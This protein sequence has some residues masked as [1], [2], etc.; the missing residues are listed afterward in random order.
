MAF[1]RDLPFLNEY[2]YACPTGGWCGREDME[3]A[4]PPED[5]GYGTFTA[6]KE[7]PTR[8]WWRF[9]TV[10][11]IDKMYLSDFPQSKISYDGCIGCAHPLNGWE[12]RKLNEYFGHEQP[13]LSDLLDEIDDLLK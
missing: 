3:W 10:Q 2:V 9:A 8:N 1:D 13:K 11:G 12:A 7:G 4:T 5:G 6:T